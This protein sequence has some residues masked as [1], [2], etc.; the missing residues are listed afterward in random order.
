VAEELYARRGIDRVRRRWRAD[1]HHDDDDRVERKAP[2]PVVANEYRN[3]LAKLSPDGHWLTYTSYETGRTEVYVRPFP[4]PGGATQVS[5][6]G[7]DQPMWSRDGRELFYR[8][9]VNMIASSF[10]RGTV[11]SRAVLFQDTF[12]R[13]NATNYDVLPGGGFVMLRSLG[14]DQD[15]TVLVNW[16]TEIQR[17]ARAGER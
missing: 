7:G 17:R 12:D 6:D 1:S 14:E 5:V 11:T 15:L 9:G 4:G 3:R 16:K 8:D 13:S 10:S 2:R